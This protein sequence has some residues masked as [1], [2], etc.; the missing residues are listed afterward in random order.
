[1][2]VCVCRE[3]LGWNQ[4]MLLVVYD[5]GGA[6]YDHVVPPHAD[7][8]SD[9]APCHLR[10]QCSPTANAFDF[11]RLGGRSSALVISPW[12]NAGVVNEPVL[13]PQNGSQFEL[14]SIPATVKNLFNL[15]GFLTKRDK[16]AGSL[17]ELTLNRTSPRTDCPL[18]LPAA[19]PPA[20]PWGPVPNGSLTD[21]GHAEP[22]HCGR[23]EQVCRGVEALTTKQKRLVGTYS[24]LT[25]VEP[26]E[27]WRET[28][29]RRDANTWLGQRWGEF[30]AS[31]LGI[32]KHPVKEE[33]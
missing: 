11:R 30:M 1:M 15:S 33:L 4:T 23:K 14:S 12:V 2:A 26:P 9:D 8:P 32:N 25:G 21:S 24:A 22:Q 27:S 17:H 20:K 16:W 19:P 13:G 10:D 5:D 28:W 7:V 31:G 29:S 6:Y 18:H 3:T